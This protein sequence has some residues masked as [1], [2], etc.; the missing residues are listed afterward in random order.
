MARNKTKA[1]L[2]VEL[3]TLK[4]A[5]R[6]DGVVALGTTATKWIGL[7]VIAHY[8]YLSID[9]LAGK[10]TSALINLGVLGNVEVSLGL[11]I[12]VTAI[13]VA[14]ALQQR[15]LR[16][17]TVERLQLRITEFEKQIDPKRSSSQLTTRGET[18]PEDRA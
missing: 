3:R 6:S 13:S 14:Y 1:Q 12:T 8:A 9:A 18:R 10:E 4:A 5:K 2:E 15:K 11:S 17:D 16:R 7:G